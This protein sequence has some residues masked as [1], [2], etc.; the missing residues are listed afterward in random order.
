MILPPIYDDVMSLNDY[1]GAETINDKIII[2]QDGKY[3]LS[4]GYRVDLEPVYDKISLIDDDYFLTEKDGKFGLLGSSVSI[5]AEYDEIQVPEIMGWIKARKGNVWGYFDAD[6]HFTEDISKAF[7]LKIEWFWDYEPIGLERS[8]QLFNDYS[9]L[10]NKFSFS[11]LQDT[12]EIEVLEN[13]NV[14]DKMVI[15]ANKLTKKVGLRLY[16]TMTDLIPPKYDELYHILGNEYA[17]RLNDKYG[18]VLADGKGTELCPP[19]YDEIKKTECSDFIALVRIGEKWGVT[20]F[21]DNEIPTN[22]EYDEIIEG[23]HHW[24]FKLLLKKE[25][26]VGV[27]MDDI[28]IPPLYDG[29]FVPEVFGWIRVCKDGEWGYLDVNNE[30]T[31]DES[32]AYLCYMD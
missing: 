6:G 9:S 17:Y 13:G 26:K 8:N 14:F 23:K 7:Q 5:P 29:F 1:W 15:Y 30:F 20:H 19:I 25:G 4:C 27:Q 12:V 2:K 31:P 11:K 3:G 10:I 16:V 24:Y 18:F 28:F 22:P 21:Y 32:K